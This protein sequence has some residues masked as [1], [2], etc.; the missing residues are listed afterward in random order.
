MSVFY[1]QGC[2]GDLN[3]TTRKCLGRIHDQ[4]FAPAGLDMLITSI[5]DGNHSAGSLHPDGGA[6]DFRPAHFTKGFI[7]EVCGSGFD[8]I[9]SNNGAMHVEYDPKGK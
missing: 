8:V 2:V 3:P 9:E 7:K 1:K 5:R 6:F 4:L